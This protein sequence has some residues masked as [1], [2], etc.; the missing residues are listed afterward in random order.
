MAR[1]ICF[2]C[3]YCN[4]R[5]DLGA[6]QVGE[7]LTCNCGERLRVPK[8]SGMSSRDKRLI[9]WCVEFVI[10]GGGGGLLGFGLGALI[11][12]KLLAAWWGFWWGSWESALIVG[13]TTIVGFVA[14]GLGGERGVNWLG[15]KIRSWEDV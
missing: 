6:D 14:G 15:S 7:R 11:V 8:R 4:R 10:Y 5:Y 12:S 9:D 3:W 13:G 1:K 2:R